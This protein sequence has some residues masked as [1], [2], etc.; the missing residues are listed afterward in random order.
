MAR[1][2]RLHLCLD[3]AWTA[4]FKMDISQTSEQR[5]EGSAWQP[6]DVQVLRN[7]NKSGLKWGGR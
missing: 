1:L 5:K 7:W 2:L 6:R 4:R 3:N